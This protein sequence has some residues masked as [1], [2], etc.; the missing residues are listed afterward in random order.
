MLKKRLSN[1]A[2]KALKQINTDRENLTVIF[3]DD[4]NVIQTND[5]DYLLSVIMLE[6][7]DFGMDETQNYCNEL[8]DR[9]N[10]AYDELIEE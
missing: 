1:P 4:C 8:G 10:M 3:N 5:L 9:L 7:A 2:Y 6:F